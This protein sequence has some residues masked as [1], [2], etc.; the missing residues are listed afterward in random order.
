MS[1]DRVRTSEDRPLGDRPRG[2]N[3][4]VLAFALFGG[5]AP[6]T[7][8]LIGSYAVATY[9]CGS[10]LAIWLLHGLTAGTAAVSIA[11]VF[12]SAFILRRAVRRPRGERSPE[13]DRDQFLSSGGLLLGGLGFM[14]IVFGEVAVVMAGCG[15]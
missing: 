13:D 11:A 4:W 5:T 6:W 3:P 10:D 8:H 14:A 9:L 15:T 1:A 2:T 12:T 7:A